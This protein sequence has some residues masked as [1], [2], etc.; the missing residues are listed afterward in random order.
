MTVE[1]GGGQAAVNAVAIDRN[2]KIMLA[3]YRTNNNNTTDRGVTTTEDL[4]LMR[5]TTAGDPDGAFGTNGRVTTN[6]LGQGDGSSHDVV[7]AMALQ[8]SNGKIVVVG[9]ADNLYFVA[10]YNTGGAL[11]GEF[12]EEK[13]SGQ[14]RTGL[15][16]GLI[17]HRWDGV[18]LRK[19]WQSSPT[20][21]Y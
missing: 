12:G 4:A 19:T 10:R 13:P 16:G 17:R 11:D 14:G 5:L 3:G 18:I 7:N 2:N 9:T 1:W 21:R 15:A 8:P 20:A 6:I